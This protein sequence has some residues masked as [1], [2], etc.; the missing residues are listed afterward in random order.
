MSQFTE[1]YMHNAEFFIWAN[2][3]GCCLVIAVVGAWKSLL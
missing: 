1:L 3:F 2:L